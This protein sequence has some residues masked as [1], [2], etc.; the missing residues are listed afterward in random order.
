[1][2]KPIVAVS[3]GSSRRPL[4]GWTPGTKLNSLFPNIADPKDT[5]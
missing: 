2:W 3:A 4:L 1:M 5:P